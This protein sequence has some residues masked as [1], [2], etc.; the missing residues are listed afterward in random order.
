MPIELPNLD[1]R[2]FTDLV[3][4]GRRLIPGFAPSWTDHN[5]SDPGITFIEL[6]AYTVESLMYRVNRVSDANKRAF[7]RLLQ[8]DWT[9]TPG[10]TIEDELSVVI[11]RTRVEERAVTA[12]DF[13]RLALM[14]P[15]VARAYCLAHRNLAA[16]T[17]Q[18]AT[19]APGHTSIV[20]ILQRGP[21]AGP[22]LARVQGRLQARSL[23]TTQVHVVPA[24]TLAVA[25]HLKLAIYP[26][27]TPDAVKTRAYA[28]LGAFFDP[29]VG[30]RDGDG[31][32][33][34]APVYRADVYAL[35]DG[36][37]G[38]DYVVLDPAHD[39]VSALGSPTERRFPAP[40]N[41]VGLML[42]PNE[43]VAFNAGASTIECVAED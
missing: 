8:P 31:W 34:G 5:I 33:L 24:A 15:G 17:E 13:E 28:A 29:V 2:T 36:V 26:D 38:V 3:E 27:Q 10:A 35:M 30:G 32:P 11:N 1:D 19:E 41:Y 7:V 20:V 37:E 6:F 40:G 25:V 42:R 14:V 16:G 23:L 21:S 43:V 39:D 9:P 18:A 12:S 4:E 22:T